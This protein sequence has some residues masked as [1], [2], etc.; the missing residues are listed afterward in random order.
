MTSPAPTPLAPA[1]PDLVLDAAR[2]ARV[3]EGAVVATTA[4]AIFRVEG[5][6]ALTCLQG[7]LTNDL[8]APGDGSLVY[9][10]FLAP[11]GA[12]VADYWVLREADGFTLVAA[13][14][15]REPTLELFRR[16]LPPRLARVA[17]RT[18]EWRVL[19]CVGAQGFTSLAR[20]GLAPLP[21][22]CARATRVPAGAGDAGDVA[23]AL[24]TERA[25]FAALAVGAPAAV[26][27]VAGALHHA[28]AAA[29]DADDLE[30]ARILA[31]WP[32]LGAEIAERTLPQEVRYDELGGVSYT[33]GCYTGQ[34]TVARLHFRGHTNRELRGLRWHGPWRPGADRSVTREGREVGT[35]RSTVS[36]GGSVGL[37]VLRREVE[38][39]EEVVAAGGPATVV[40]LPFAPADLEA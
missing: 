7:L 32:A 30:A 3:R 16:T 13:P 18:G 25:W 4:P 24:G 28:G 5:P 40:D 34:E 8:A 29:G 39:G 2:L 35:V 17:D 33:K 27:A 21:E 15:A 6:G 26:A 14:A 31:G 11:K 19:W 23:L 38:V 37:A 12:I 36:A 1:P 10:A 20:A 22:A 9:G